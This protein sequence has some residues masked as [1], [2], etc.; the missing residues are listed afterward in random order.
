[1]AKTE[2]TQ[3]Q[4]TAVMGSAPPELYFKDCGEDC[5]PTHGLVI[6]RWMKR[7]ESKIPRHSAYSNE[8]SQSHWLC[9]S[10]DR[11]FDGYD[12]GSWGWNSMDHWRRRIVPAL[13]GMADPE[14]PIFRV[15]KAIA[16]E[17]RR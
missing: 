15:S 17:T 4:W 3:G 12:V 10:G 13:T 8:G 11:V 5:W 7:C 14:W 16:V 1:M 6:V 9:V 2:I